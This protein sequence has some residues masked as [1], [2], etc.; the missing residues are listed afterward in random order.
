MQQHKI[1]V[2]PFSQHE[3]I[4]ISKIRVLPPE[5]L[6]E[7]EDFIDFLRQTSEDRQ[8][9]QAAAKL[10]EDSFSKVWDNPEDA[11]YDRL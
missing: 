7:V 3:Q 1:K 11:E 4:L 2:A 9:R 5:R 6:I 10:S 8:L